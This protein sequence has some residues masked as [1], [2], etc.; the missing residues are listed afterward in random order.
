VIGNFGRVSFALTFVLLA[1]G[2]FALR[3]DPEATIYSDPYRFDGY[4]MGTT[5]SVQYAAKLNSEAALAL[6][7]AVAQLL[8]T[9]DKE[10]FSTYAPT[11]EIS[12]LSK[13]PIETSVEVSVEMAVVLQ[14]A[15]RVSSETRGAFDV[16][17]AP[18]VNLWGFGPQRKIKDAEPSPE[19]LRDALSRVNYHALKLDID[20][21][22]LMRT[23]DVAIDLSA[24]AKGYAVD[25]VAELLESAEVYNY[26]VE[27]GGELRISGHKDESMRG[28]VPAIEAPLSGISQIYEIL[29]S[30]GDSIAVAG[31]GD[32]RNYFEVDGKRYSHEIDPRSGRPISHTLAAV[33]VIDESAMRADALA[34]AYM[35]MGAEEAEAAANAVSQAAYFIV[36]AGVEP[37]GEPRFESRHTQAFSRYLTQ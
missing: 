22:T 7:S 19:N 10:I 3:V 5:Y 21:L 20:R 9:L 26:F 14:E 31:S 27:I 23:S 11:S 15:L 34:T 18:L 33:T 17:V 29:L 28:W 13:A 4:T 12:R 8:V 2:Y 1:L 16:T 6:E 24:I 25:R 30:R 36:R 37:T 35:I 32:Y